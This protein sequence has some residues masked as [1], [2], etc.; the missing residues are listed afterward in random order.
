MSSTQK[1]RPE[2]VRRSQ[3]GPPR[4]RPVRQPLAAA[5]RRPPMRHGRTGGG[6]RSGAH[7][8]P[9]RRS[10]AAGRK[11]RRV[12]ARPSRLPQDGVRLPYDHRHLDRGRRVAGQPGDNHRRRLER[13]GRRA[14]RRGQATGQ[15]TRR[16]GDHAFELDAPLRRGQL[17]GA[18]GLPPG[19]GGRR[20]LVR[21]KEQGYQ[22]L[23]PRGPEDCLVGRRVLDLRHNA[24]LD[25]L[26]GDSRKSL[27]AGPGLPGRQPDD[28]R[29]GADRR[30]F[31][32]PF[33]RRIDATSAYEYLEKR[34]NRPVRCL[35]VCPSRCFTPSAWES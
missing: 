10:W 11:D 21:P 23:F 20:S 24:Q 33:F 19:N 6:A 28:S 29:G 3:P 8:R 9:R 18:R 31:V 35:P 17:L 1:I 12:E 4:R 32:L 7:F 34:F 15:N 13:V 27:R 26:H 14:Q 30:F 5:R 16:L 25:H 2:G 22:R